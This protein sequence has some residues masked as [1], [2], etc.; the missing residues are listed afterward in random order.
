MGT[1]LF[2]A[3]IL[4]SGNDLAPI[5]LF[6]YNRPWHTRQTL[7]A[8]QKNDLA[9][10]STLFIYADG[11]KENATPEELEKIAE[12]RSLISE[13]QWCKTV[14]II[15]SESNKGLADSIISGVTEIVNRFGKIIVLEDD[16][17]TSV[18]FLKYMNDALKMYQDED[19]V[20]HISGYMYPIKKSIF[21]RETYFLSLTSC[22]GW[23]TWKNSWMHF[24]KNPK[25]QIEQ[26][27]KDNLWNDF[28]LNGAHNNFEAQLREN[29]SKKNNTWAIFWY[30]SVFVRNGLCLHPYKSLV[31]NIGHDGSGVNSYQLEHK[32]N[33][34]YIKYL[35]SYIKVYKLELQ[36]SK[37]P[38]E[39]LGEYF[40]SIL[41]FRQLTLRDTLYIK[42]MQILDRIKS[43]FK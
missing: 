7:E 28:N 19:K 30:Y 21:A 20:M 17:V 33:P 22:W 31:R 24:E 23:G 2:K 39:L 43:V 8:L 6:V 1:I 38:K 13:S 11:P 32:Q 4:E 16:I 36:I 12:V 42:R 37:K 25:K 34:F 5:V 18:G 26:L 29:A 9:D 3:A 27:N 15:A 14:E 41:K 35:Q 10:K 40:I